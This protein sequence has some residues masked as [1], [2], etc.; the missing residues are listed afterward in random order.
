[1]PRLVAVICFALV[2]CGHADPDADGLSGAEERAAGTDPR[3]PDSDGDGLLDGEEVGFGLDPLDALDHGYAGAWPLQTSAIKDQLSGDASLETRIGVGER[4]PRLQ[5]ADQFGDTVDLYDFA[6][7]GQ[8]VLIDLSA[9]WCIACMDLSAYL[10][11]SLTAADLGLDAD[12]AVALDAVK[13]RVLTRDVLWLTVLGESRYYYN[14]TQA[15]AALWAS[16]Y[17]TGLPVLADAN[18]DL[19]DWILRVT[20]ALPTLVVLDPDMTV[21][22]WSISHDTI[23]DAVGR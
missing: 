18:E 23:A 3:A 10:V 16:E 22:A 15:D 13:E 17:P 1:M 7:H 21:R 4:F 2:A 6:D 20:G 9:G 14:P 5:L 19:Y 8:M 12:H 11:G